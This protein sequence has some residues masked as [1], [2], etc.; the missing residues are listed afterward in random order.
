MKALPMADVPLADWPERLEEVLRDRCQVL[1]R[2]TV[3]AETDS[4]QD[5][6]R[7]MDARAGDVVIAGAQRAGRGRLGRAWIDAPGASLAVT[8]VVDRAPPERLAI[9]SAVGAA[10]AAERVLGRE[11]GIRW[12]ND[13]VVDG[14]KLAGILVE[15]DEHKALIGIGLNVGQTVWP[16][17]LAGIAV[18]L[19]ELGVIV[20]RVGVAG[21]LLESV[22]DAMRMDDAAIVEAFAARD[23]LLGREATFLSNGS[24]CSGIVQHVDPARGLGVRVEGHIA[25]LPAATTSLRAQRAAPDS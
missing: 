12:P 8:V 20:D 24:A 7:R 17:A 19:A 1:Q 14:R 3:L 22:D 13:L 16:E 6:A 21:A 9:A 25:W 18:S 23:V 4:T 10:R 11:V 15:Q 5:A 2:I